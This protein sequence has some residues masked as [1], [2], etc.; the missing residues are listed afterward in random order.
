[1][2]VNGGATES[3]QR[4]R[5]GVDAAKADSGQPPAD[6]RPAVVSKT[7]RRDVLVPARERRPSGFL[8]QN[9]ARETR[10]PSP[11]YC[12]VAVL[13]RTGGTERGSPLALA[14]VGS[15]THC[16]ARFARYVAERPPAAWGFQGMLLARLPRRRRPGSPGSCSS[17]DGP[18]AVRSESCPV[19]SSRPDRSRSP[20]RPSSATSAP[21]ASSPG[22]AWTTL[23]V[24]PDHPYAG[25][26]IPPPPT[27]SRPAAAARPAGDTQPPGLPSPSVPRRYTPCSRLLHPAASPTPVIIRP[28]SSASSLR[29]RV[30]VASAAATALSSPSRTPMALR[31][32]YRLIRDQTGD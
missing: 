31:P 29:D 30:Y 17:P 23:P 12:A 27:D 16:R 24:V 21:R 10:A 15:A 26:A 19:P 25:L 20:D 6:R 28:A 32:L 22:P 9:R 11:P 5:Q 4:R 18:T 1:M 8:V 7:L 14:V 13:L 3:R 2:P